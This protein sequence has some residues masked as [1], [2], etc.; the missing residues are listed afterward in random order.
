MV[1]N[2]A[3]AQELIK[4]PEV[5]I[6]QEPTLIV[7]PEMEQVSEEQKVQ[8]VPQEKLP[9]EPIMEQ[10]I[11]PEQKIE[12][13]NTKSSVQDLSEVSQE[14]DNDK[15]M[16]LKS[17]KPLPKFYSLLSKQNYRDTILNAL[18]YLAQLDVKI[19]SFDSD[20]GFLLFDTQKN[21]YLI[22][23]FEFNNRQW[24]KI[25]PMKENFQDDEVLEKFM[26]KFT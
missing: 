3:L 24:I 21:R 13:P 19:I 7:L 10:A 22:T 14:K 9:Q 11:E 23:I 15:I 4:L 2:F 25:L 1:S 6:K 18:S 8:E 20:K 16:V 17:Q 5:D 26:K 12:E